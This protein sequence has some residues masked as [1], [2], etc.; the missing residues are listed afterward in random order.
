[1]K[2]S[3]LLFLKTFKSHATSYRGH[4]NCNQRCMHSLTSSGDL[5]P[6]LQ[7]MDDRSIVMLGEASH[8]THD[9]YTWRAA[10]SKKLIQEKGFQ[11]IAVEGDWPD[12]LFDKTAM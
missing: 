11:F 10:Y 3:W 9:Y 5:G 7:D 8:G 1:V 4:N 2:F 6:L 12:W